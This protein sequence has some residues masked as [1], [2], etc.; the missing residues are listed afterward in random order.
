MNA[1]PLISSSRESTITL[2][3]AGE[4]ISEFI[5]KSESAS[6]SFQKTNKE[7]KSNVSEE[8]LEKLSVISDLISKEVTDK[9]D[10]END[11]SKMKTPT[12]PSKSHGSSSHKSSGSHMSG[13]L[14]S[15]MKASVDT[16]E[17]SSKKDKKEKKEKK[18]EKKEKTD[19]KDSEE[20]E[21]KSEKKEKKSEKKE[22]KEKKRS[23]E[24]EMGSDDSRSKRR[25]KQID[26]D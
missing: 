22:K 11:T 21:K 10:L 4:L 17:K 7:R 23:R 26:F 19:G 18:S 2:A 24:A 5:T 6:Q 13:D 3:K 8:V 14:A 9:G 1:A 15:L 12:F 20:K 25:S 16:V